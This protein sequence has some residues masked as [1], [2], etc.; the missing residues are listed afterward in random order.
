MVNVNCYVPGCVSNNRSYQYLKFYK[1]PKDKARRRRWKKLTRNTRE[2]D[3]QWTC[4]CRLHFEGGWKKEFYSD[5]SI[6][7]SDFYR[8]PKEEPRRSMWIK[9]I[10]RREENN[11]NLWIPSS[12]NDRIC[13]EHFV[14]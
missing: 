8:I 2:R 4:L 5:P 7:L 6:F 13:S 1:L 3:S 14:K 12:D 10:N 11:G 9:A